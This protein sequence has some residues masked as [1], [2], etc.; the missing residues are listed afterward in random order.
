MPSSTNHI[1]GRSGR[2]VYLL[3]KVR[4]AKESIAWE[5]R[6]QYKG[7][8]LTCPVGL[9]IALY[10]GDK[11][12]HDVDNIK[13]LLDALTGIVYEDDGQIDDLHI[14]KS[15]DKENPRV[16]LCITKKDTVGVCILKRNG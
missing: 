14:T 13:I 3:T 1:Y 4:K 9:K 16:E 7:E 11:R 10:W 6:A 2:G 15:Y 12:K 5:A 8:L